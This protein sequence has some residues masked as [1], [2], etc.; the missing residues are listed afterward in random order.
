M[1]LDRDDVIARDKTAEAQGEGLERRRFMGGA[2]LRA[3]TNRAGRHV[4]T[5]GLDAIEVEDR[6]VIDRV[7]HLE[8]GDDLIRRHGE[9][10]AE[11][12]RDLSGGNR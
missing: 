8:L 12:E 3:K 10:R 9:V 5:P 6:A 2:G 11:V 7:R 1:N 4:E